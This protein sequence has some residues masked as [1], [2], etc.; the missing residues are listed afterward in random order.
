MGA[1]MV[2]PLVKNGNL[3]DALPSQ[4]TLHVVMLGLDSAGKTTA[5][6]RLKFDQYLNTVPT[7]GFNCEK[8]QGTIG[9]AKGVHFLVW[10]VGGQEKLRPL[11]RSYTRCTDGIL[12]VIDSV[13]TE[14]MEEAKMELMRTA[15]CPDNQGVPVLILANKQDLPNACGA[16]E[17]E[18][19]LGLNELYSP[20]PNISI[21]TS[22]NSSSTVNLIG[23]SMANQSIIESSSTKRTSSHLHS[24]MIHIKPALETGDQKDTLTE[25]ALPAF[26]YSHSY[27][28]PADLD[29]QTQREVK[30]CFHNKKHNRA[31]S[32]SMQFRG[33]YIQP[34]CAITGEGLQE[35]L[36]A[37]YDMILK[38]RKINK[39]QKKKL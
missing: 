30:K 11:W 16:I 29:Q 26:I 20:V 8:V 32:N 38:R 24:S 4:A 14:R 31:S 10:D 15:K 36:D 35:G 3:L 23:C 27:N 18:K 37:L 33:W 39:S 22:S 19:L 21:L 1:T 9:K 6:Y 5:L 25:E 28:D 13:D 17:L 2:K 34:T 12:F 7:I